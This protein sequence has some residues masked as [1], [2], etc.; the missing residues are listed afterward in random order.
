MPFAVAR[1]RY[2]RAG[3]SASAV[4]Y[5]MMAIVVQAVLSI[6]LAVGAISGNC[7]GDFCR[8]AVLYDVGAPSLF[9]WLR[10][11]CDTDTGV[12]SLCR[13]Y[14]WAQSRCWLHLQER[15]AEFG[16]WCAGDRRT[17]V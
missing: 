8:M 14:P 16:I 6:L 17:S 4:S 15:L 3:G 5:A 13:R 11:G 9:S 2:F 1:D 10:T 12:P 7:F